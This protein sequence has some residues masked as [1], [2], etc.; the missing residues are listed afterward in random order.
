MEQ[1]FIKTLLVTANCGSVFED[2]KLLEKWIDEFVGHVKQVQPD[3]VALHLQEVGGKTYEKSM[4]YV[5]KFIQMLCEAN[6]FQD[7]DRIRVFL[8][9]DYNSAEHFTALGNLY[10]ISKSIKSLKTW[11][12]LTHEWEPVEGKNIHTG[13]I[14]TVPTKEKS[15]FPQNFFPECKWSRK[16][17]LR[18]RW[19]INGT[20][21]DLVNIHLFHDASN[22]AACQEYPSVYCKSRRRAL[23]H[24]LERFHQDDVNV[25]VP[26]FIFGDFNFRCDTEGVIKELTENLTMHRVQNVKNDNT[27][28]HYRNSDGDNVLTVG[29]K[30]F[31]HSEHQTKFKEEWVELESIKEFLYEY[32]INFAPSYPYEENSELPNNYMST[33]CPSWC[34][35]VLIS[36]AAKK[37][38]VNGEDVAN[39]SETSPTYGII[40]EN[41]CMGDHKPVYLS[42]RIKID[43]GIVSCYGEHETT[44]S[45]ENASDTQFLV[46]GSNNKYNLNN[47]YNNNY[48]N[49]V[50]TVPNIHNNINSVVN[51]QEQQQQL[52][53]EIASTS[54]NDNNDNRSSI[55]LL[56]RKHF[57]DN[58]AR[59]YRQDNIESHNSRRATNNANNSQKLKNSNINNN[60]SSAVRSPISIHV[61]DAENLSVCMCSLYNS[62][63]NSDDNLLRPK[64]SLHGHLSADNLQTEETNNI[65]PICRNIIKKQPIERRTLISKRLLLAN[66]I[67]VN[68]IDSHYLNTF[69]GINLK[70]DPYTPESPDFDSPYL[71]SD[72]SDTNRD[73]DSSTELNRL[74]NEEDEMMTEVDTEKTD[75]NPNNNNLTARHSSNNN[76]LLNNV[77]SMIS[78]TSGGV[79][80]TQL[81][82]R[83][84]RLQQLSPECSDND[85]HEN[86][87]KTIKLIAEQ[88]IPI[89]TETIKEKRQE[90]INEGNKKISG[91]KE[92]HN[93]V[94]CCTG[95]ECCIL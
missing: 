54:S 66:D 53:F 37:L 74:K 76:N 90:S 39:D 85:D 15:K 87:T 24:T 46:V 18:T 78:R 34:D 81:K 59:I 67:I 16:G 12:F 22:L 5:Q 75:N 51:V 6:D 9:E 95:K 44:K 82:S 27:K 36:P 58:L 3:F 1:E 41:I 93:D 80:P 91:K 88:K 13:N 62:R 49:H 29:K 4:E 94:P 8:D 72:S 14:E 83:L 65:C 30:E 60:R 55:C 19:S 10:F 61:I 32:P 35:R 40:G 45:N 89:E 17:F 56:C 52:S 71:E 2:P 43:Q 48:N 68:R 86:D 57:M 11:N 26:Y 7:F 50:P 92:K 64:D 70:Q 28:V 21:L 38:I 79:S 31:S 77:S 84:E 73:N 69:S 23:L 47:I 25:V 63:N 42:I 33:R 20:I